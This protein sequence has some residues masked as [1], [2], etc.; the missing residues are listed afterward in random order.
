MSDTVLQN[1]NAIRLVDVAIEKKGKFESLGTDKVISIDYMESILSPFTSAQILISDSVN[2]INTLPIEGGE[3]IRF[4]LETTWNKK[5]IEY[6]LKIYKIAGRTQIDAKKQTYSLMCVSEEALVNETVRV[7][8]QLRDNPQ[9]IIKKLIK[10][11]LQSTK[12]IYSEP[13]RFKVSLLPGRKRPFDIIAQLLKR[14]VS[15]ATDYRASEAPTQEQLDSEESIRGS[16]GF[17]F[18][19][20]WRG[21]NFFSIDALCDRSDSKTF[22]SDKADGT[23]FEL[24]QGREP[25]TDRDIWG[26]YMDTIANTDRVEDMRFLITTFMLNSE[27]DLMSSL[28]MGKYSTKMVFFN[29]STGQYSEYVYKITESYDNMAHLGGQTKISKIPDNTGSLESKYSRVMSAILDHETWYDDPEIK[30]P[31]DKSTISPTEFADWQKYY[32][33]QSFA[34]SDLLK[35]QEATMKIPINPQI[36]AGDKIDVGIQ[37]KS[38]D[39][40]KET[41]PYDTETS[42]TYLVKEAT[43][44]YNFVNTG[45]SGAGYSTLRLFRDSYGM[46]LEPSKRGE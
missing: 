28:R 23:Q 39:K 45:S 40:D 26:P 1:A 34:R 25:Y 30:D 10:K 6:K 4:K 36:C 5:A 44:T 41:K 14:S 18:W 13:S 46:G 32:A 19:E 27:T 37:N 35:N 8:E 31:D 29:H 33:A 17:L 38:S 22:T 2:F 43:H 42:G 11:K 3:Y 15:N 24:T 20:S 12:E 7:E 9:Q 16:A 21:Y